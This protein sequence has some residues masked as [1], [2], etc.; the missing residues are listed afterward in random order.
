MFLCSYILTCCALLVINFYDVVTAGGGGGGN[1]GGAAT[2][3]Q[4]GQ[5]AA[6]AGMTLILARRP[7]SS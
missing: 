6:G 3:I 4:P 5:G 7:L 2:S 1:N